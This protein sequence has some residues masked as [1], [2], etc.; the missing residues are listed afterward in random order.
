MALV[1]GKCDSC[2][3]VRLADAKSVNSAKNIRG[4]GVE[5]MVYLYS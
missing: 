5:C 2:I 1:K 3:T 4:L